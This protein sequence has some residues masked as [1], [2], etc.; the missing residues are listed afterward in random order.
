[1]GD[2]NLGLLAAVPRHIAQQRGIVPGTIPSF[3]AQARVESLCIT[4]L[5]QGMFARLGPSI[6]IDRRVDMGSIPRPK[7]K[8]SRDRQ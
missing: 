8:K 5:S 4:I 3:A 7:G 2:D 6:I 1:M